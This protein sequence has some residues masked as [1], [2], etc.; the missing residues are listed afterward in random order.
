MIEIV[1]KCAA[2][3]SVG[4]LCPRSSCGTSPII[5]GG[6]SPIIPGGTSPIIPGGTSPILPAGTRVLLCLV[7]LAQL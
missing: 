7:G 6:T 2:G 1:M 5:P 3:S 4:R